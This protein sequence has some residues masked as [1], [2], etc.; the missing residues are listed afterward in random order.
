M[1]VPFA[2]TRAGG[3]SPE[4]ATAGSAGFDIRSAEDFELFPGMW[5]AV[6]TGLHVAIP[7]DHVG[8]ICPRSG[9]A[10]KHGVT[11]LN[12]P[13]VIDSD[14]RGEIKVL[15]INHGDDV[16]HVER[17]MRIAQMLIMKVE[18]PSLSEIDL[19]KN[20]GSTERGEGGFGSTGTA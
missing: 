1:I 13:G 20:L 16:F 17:G 2:L 18:A 7:D 11:V 3:G 4:R 10:Y 14:Y 15:L 19:I 8:L 5:A 6:K 12:T 9:L